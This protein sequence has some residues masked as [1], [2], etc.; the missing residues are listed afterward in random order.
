LLILNSEFLILNYLY[1]SRYTVEPMKTPLLFIAFFLLWTNLVSAQNVSCSDLT[2]TAITQSTTD[3]STYLITVA[4]S[5][6]PMEFINYPYIPAVLDS[7][8]DTLATGTMFYFA[9]LGNSSQD[10]PV[11]PVGGFNGAAFTAVFIYGTLTG[12]DTC[13]LSF[14]STTQSVDPV[15]TTQRIVLG[16]NPA[17]ESLHI[18]AES[19][20]IHASFTIYDDKGIEVYTGRLNDSTTRVNLSDYANGVYCISINDGSGRVSR[21]IKLAQ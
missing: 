3:S 12:S 8:G 10:Y 18:H 9:Q 11:T 16:P 1:L 15:W 5:G 20:G 13:V 4:F 6:P 17:N 7:I 19:P 21:F 14:S 2:I